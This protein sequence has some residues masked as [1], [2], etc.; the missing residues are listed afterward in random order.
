MATE[1]DE[2]RKRVY[3]RSISYGIRVERDN[4]LREGNAQNYAAAAKV[5]LEEFTGFVASEAF[6]SVPIIDLEVSLM[7]RLLTA[8]SNRPIK[9]GD[10]TDIDAMAAYL[11]YCHLYGTDRAMAELARSIDIPS[12]YDC[13]VV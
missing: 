10:A 12:R 9:Q 5:T 6:L 11:P 7:A 13:G 8:Y 1:R 2:L 3:K 4:V